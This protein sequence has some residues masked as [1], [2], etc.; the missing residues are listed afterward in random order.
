MAT[1]W[2]PA[3][4]QPYTGGSRFVEVEGLTLR[5]VIERLGQC[6][7]GLSD[8]L[9]DEEGRLQPEI[10]AAIDGETAHLGL[11]Q[12]LRENSEI[13]F[14]PAISGGAAGDSFTLTPSS[15]ALNADP[16]Q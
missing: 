10:A 16:H 15:I 2:I 3:L 8:R 13:H 14:I 7:P 6:Y 5:Q 4:L 9:L 11:I 12:P 1:V